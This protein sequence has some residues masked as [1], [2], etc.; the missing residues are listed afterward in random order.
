MYGPKKIDSGHE[1][2]N[3]RAH[4]TIVVVEENNQ[5]EIIVMVVLSVGHLGII[6]C[7]V[8]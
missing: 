5:A 1:N 4:E 7:D 3:N 2:A 6:G 8:V